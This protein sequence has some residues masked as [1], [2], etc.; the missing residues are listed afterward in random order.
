M[1]LGGN[2]RKGEILKGKGEMEKQMPL[3]GSR[4][5]KE[6]EIGS[7]HGAYIYSLNGQ[8]TTTEYFNVVFIGVYL[9]KYYL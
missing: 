3:V 5:E 9:S 2:R 8:L 7:F 4:E 1:W 6:C